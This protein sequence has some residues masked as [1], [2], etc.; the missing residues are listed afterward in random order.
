MGATM[1]VAFGVLALVVAAV[2]LYGVIAYDVAQRMRELGIRVALGARSM[3]VIRLV[4]GQAMA[5]AASGVTIG[6]GITLLA[7]RSVQPLL[8][9]ESAIDPVTYGVVGGVVV[10]VAIL[11]S[12]IPALR[13]TRADPNVALRTD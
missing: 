8:F 11:A 6:L 2:G 4:V 12:A 10:A 9:Q 3:D 1:F 13:A 7:S 5:F